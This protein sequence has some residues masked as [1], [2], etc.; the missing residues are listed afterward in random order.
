MRYSSVTINALSESRIGFNIE[1]QE[2]SSSLADDN[3]ALE[4]IYTEDQPEGE[5]K[6]LQTWTI[7]D[8]KSYESKRL[9]KLWK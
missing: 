8:D 4:I 3:P 2:N 1:E 7:T 9:S 5:R 6:S